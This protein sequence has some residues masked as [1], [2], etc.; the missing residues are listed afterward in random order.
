MQPRETTLFLLG[1]GH[2]S[3]SLAG[4]RRG[5]VKIKVDGS[6]LADLRRLKKVK[7]TCRPGIRRRGRVAARRPQ[8]GAGIVIRGGAAK[9]APT[10]GKQAGLQWEAGARHIS[11]TCS[12]P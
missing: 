10:E 2:A 3:A 4:T 1:R 5:L 7:A 6:M 8:K 12:T 9:G 11:M